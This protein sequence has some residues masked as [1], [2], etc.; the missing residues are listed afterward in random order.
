VKYNYFEIK[1]NE[2]GRILSTKQIQ[3]INTYTQLDEDLVMLRSSLKSFDGDGQPVILQ[4]GEKILKRTAPYHEID[5]ADGQNLKQLFT[6][7][8]KKTG[9]EDLIPV[10]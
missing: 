4:H 10:G 1:V 5:E 8:L 2:Q 9:H 3:S 6:E 7:Y